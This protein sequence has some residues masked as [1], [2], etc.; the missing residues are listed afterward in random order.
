MRTTSIALLPGFMFSRRAVASPL[1]RPAI[2]SPSTA[3]AL[4]FT[5]PPALFARADEV[6]E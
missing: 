2:V 4:R 5:I 3:K 1:T 6:I